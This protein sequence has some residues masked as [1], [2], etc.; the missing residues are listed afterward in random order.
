MPVAPSETAVA[1]CQQP[2]SRATKKDQQMVLSLVESTVMTKK[3]PDWLDG[4]GNWRLKL[5]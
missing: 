3:Q 4:S 2:A 5:K 1:R